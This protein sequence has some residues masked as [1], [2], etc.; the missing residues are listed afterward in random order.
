MANLLA[1]CQNQNQIF[2]FASEASPSSL[3]NNPPPPPH[4]SG[5]ASLQSCS[6]PAM[7]DAENNYGFPDDMGGDDDQS[8]VSVC[9]SPAIPPHVVP[10]PPVP[11]APPSI[12]VSW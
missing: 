2:D 10:P 12:A 1:N 7:A 11:S 4:P 3:S 9:R 5:S 6:R 8:I